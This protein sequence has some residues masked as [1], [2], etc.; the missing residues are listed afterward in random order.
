MKGNYHTHTVRCKHALEADEKY[1]QA[2]IAAGFDELGFA[3]HA[4][5]PFPDGFVGSSRMLVDQLPDYISSISNLRVKYADR[6]SVLVGLE[7]EYYPCYHDHMMRVK[8]MGVQYF[9]L[10]QHNIEPENISPYVPTI[11]KDDDVVLRYADA[12]VIGIRT[13]LFSY[14]AHPDLFMGNNP[15]ERFNKTC[16]RAADMICQAAKEQGL[17]IEYNLLGL[18]NEMDG[19]S[20][21]YPSAPF[22]QYVRKYDNEVILGVDAHAPSHLLRHDVWNEAIARMNALGYRRVETPVFPD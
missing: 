14:V 16:E 3:D 19:C 10:G 15:P 17:P 6:I 1:V 8:D 7:S 11:S 22:W 4:P 9:I 20:R 18:M 13:G 2:A 21:G 12:V 5:W